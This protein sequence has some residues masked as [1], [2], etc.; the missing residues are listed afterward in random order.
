MGNTP[1]TLRDHMPHIDTRVAAIFKID[2]FA[3]GDRP[4]IEA[5]DEV[6]RGGTTYL[7]SNE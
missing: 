7:R 2:L 3:P 6:F 1:S 5:G 4:I